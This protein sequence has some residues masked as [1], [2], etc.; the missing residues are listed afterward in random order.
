VNPAS[1]GVA[2]DGSGHVYI[3]G[4]TDGSLA[5]QNR[6]EIDAFVAKYSAD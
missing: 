3:G 4:Y 5:G 6:G 1:T 2:T